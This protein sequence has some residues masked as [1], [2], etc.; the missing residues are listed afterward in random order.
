[1]SDNQPPPPP[2]QPSQPP[3]PP[4]EQP[5]PY[6]PSSPPPPPPPGSGQPY[7][8]QSYPQQSYPQQPYPQQPYPQQPYQPPVSTAGQPGDL[9]TRFLARIIDAVLVGVVSG[10]VFGIL[11]VAA[12]GI[13]G[14]S[15]SYFYSVLSTIASTALA[16][17][18]FVFM[19]SSRGQTVGKM[20]LKLRVQSPEGRNPTVEQSLRRNSWMAISLIGIVPILGGLVAGLASLAAVIYIAV[21]INAD[22]VARRGW[23]DQFGGTRVVR[24]A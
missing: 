1:M 4:P 16:L 23:H 5:A 9:G 18:Y 8:Q 3:P 11:G 15:G 13:G 20:L 17:G 22:A 10:V 21:T 6:Q 24:T 2:E 19:E 14:R 12:W 7:P